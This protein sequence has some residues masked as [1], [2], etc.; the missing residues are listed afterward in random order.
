MSVYCCLLC[1]LQALPLHHRV[2]ALEGWR[3]S[4]IAQLR[5]FY[6]VTQPNIIF[7]SL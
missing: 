5:V 3:D 2:K 7:L 6:Q 1:V 4:P